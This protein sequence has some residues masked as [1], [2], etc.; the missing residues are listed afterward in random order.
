M[1]L[2]DKTLILLR[3]GQDTSIVQ[4]YMDDIIFAESSRFLVA[5]FLEIM[6]REFETSMMG[7]LAF[8][9]GLQIKQS[10]DD[11]LSSGRSNEDVKLQI[12]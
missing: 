5:K 9:L 3:H 10:K 6:S 2:V 11:T 4:I 8:F 12:N 7:E 1:S